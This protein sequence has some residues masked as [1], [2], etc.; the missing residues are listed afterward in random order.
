MK[1]KRTFV[2]AFLT[3]F[4]AAPLGAQNGWVDDFMRRYQPPS[5]L[6]S[7]GPISTNVSTIT[8]GGQVLQTGVVPITMTDVIN[9]ML[10]R[11]LDIQSNRLSPRSS[12]FSSLVFYRAL[13]P[14]IRFSGTIRRNTNLSTST[15]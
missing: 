4:M 12:Y 8:V 13:Q 2:Y 3:L 10:D 15:L 6:S 11:N 1:I 5:T 14:S 7:S 9:L